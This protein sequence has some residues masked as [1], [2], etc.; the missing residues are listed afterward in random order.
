MSEEKSAKN[1]CVI[2]LSINLFDARAIALRGDGKVIA[3][4]EKPGGAETANDT[5]KILFELLDDIFAQAGKH[6]GD[7]KKIGLAFGGIVHQKKEVIFWPQEC[8]S[9]V[10]VTF[11]LKEHIEKKFSLPVVIE[12]DANAC[13]LAE[14]TLNFSKCKNI[15]YLFSGVGCG[16]IL[17]GKIYRGKNG[18]AGEVFLNSDHNVMASRLGDFSFLHQW[19]ADLYMVKRAKELI[20]LGKESSLINKITSVGSLTLKD[21]LRDAVKKDRLAREV[22]REGA[23]AL[24]AK[25]AF[26]INLLDPEA[27]VIG[28]GMEDGAEIFLEE[29]LSAIKTFSL[30]EARSGCKIVMSPLGKKAASLGAAYLAFGN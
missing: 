30:S 4:V 11:P 10:H 18:A 12:N 16:M 14:Y 22:V 26:L 28:G 19:P 3:E 29:C 21:I 23:F 6:K 9:F 8:A 17:D 2:G 7:I 15:I 5:I 1:K 20:S 24:G 13:A 27:V 25:A